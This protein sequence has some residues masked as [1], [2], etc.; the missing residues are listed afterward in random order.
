LA[1][2]T[3]WAK[4]AHKGYP[5]GEEWHRSDGPPG[6]R[7]QHPQ[8][9]PRGSSGGDPVQPAT[10]K[11]TR[12]RG[13]EPRGQVWNVDE[14]QRPASSIQRVAVPTAHGDRRAGR[15]VPIQRANGGASR[16][17][18]LGHLSCP[19]CV[20]THRGNCRSEWG[21]R[22][23]TLARSACKLGCLRLGCESCPARVTGSI[24]GAPIK[25]PVAM[26]E[27]LETAGHEG[28]HGRETS[29][30]A[31]PVPDRDSPP[32]TDQHLPTQG[33]ARGGRSRAAGSNRRPQ[34]ANSAERWSQWVGDGQTPEDKQSSPLRRG[35]VGRR[36]SA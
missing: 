30:G 26:R 1:S 14:A 20:H 6:Q 27:R 13:Q 18:I 17:T 8:G 10:H 16:K 5:R 19:H 9:A 31:G 11:S 2:S 23:L 15:R 3:S 22:S 33:A 24:P 29:G 25:T 7:A 21:R 35:S 34:L 12:G 32:P 28:R 36:L 4:S